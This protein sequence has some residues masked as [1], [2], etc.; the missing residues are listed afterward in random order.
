MAK[1][2]VTEE[3]LSQVVD[4]V[5]DAIKKVSDKQIT[6]EKVTEKIDTKITEIGIG[7]IEENVSNLE[8]KF[9]GYVT[10]EALG[11]KIEEVI[12]VANVEPIKE[13][14]KTLNGR[15][16]VAGSEDPGAPAETHTEQPPIMVAPEEPI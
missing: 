1:K 5:V 8:R 16:P 4:A 13:K 10:N 12:G 14:I 6:E 15:V 2:F 11:G 3:G 9:E 7:H